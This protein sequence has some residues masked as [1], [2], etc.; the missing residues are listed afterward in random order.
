MKRLFKFT[1][2]IMAVAL[3]MV[4]TYHFVNTIPPEGSSKESQATAI[5]EEA[6]CMK[7]HKKNTTKDNHKKGYRMFDME[8]VW[9]KIKKEEALNETHLAKIEMETIILGTI[10]RKSTRLNS[11]H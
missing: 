1:G 5:F 8:E 4:V 11:S 10:D 7:C 2:F 9:D 6:S 3:V